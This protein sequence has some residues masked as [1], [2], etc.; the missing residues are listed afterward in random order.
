MPFSSYWKNIGE[1]NG[2]Q[3]N[4]R[5]TGH[6]SGNLGKEM[7]GVIC[8]TL[9][10]FPFEKRIYCTSDV[11]GELT[12]VSQLGAFFELSKWVERRGKK[13]RHIYSSGK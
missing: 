3:L 5:R 1:N 9:D 10:Y 4:K 6:L 8:K 13:I 12:Y 2:T 7:D 11:S